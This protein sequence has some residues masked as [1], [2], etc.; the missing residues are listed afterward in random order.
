MPPLCYNKE[1]FIFQLNSTPI[2]TKQPG[3]LHQYLFDKY[4]IEIPVM[5]LEG[6]NLLRYSIQAFN[7]QEDLDI[8]YDALKDIIRTTDLIEK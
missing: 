5:T 6:Q 1:D 3:E 4:K 7:S 2:R 8:L